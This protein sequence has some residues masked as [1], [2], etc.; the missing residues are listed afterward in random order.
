MSPEQSL[1]NAAVL[2]R[3]LAEDEAL[4]VFATLSPALADRLKGAMATN[5]AQAPKKQEEIPVKYT[6]LVAAHSQLVSDAGRYVRQ[7]L[8]QAFADELAPPAP[9]PAQDAPLSGLERLGRLDPATIAQVCGAE[10]PQVIAAILVRLERG[11][12]TAALNHLPQPTQADVLLRIARLQDIHPMALQDLDEVLSAT[13]DRLALAK[14]GA[15]GGLQTAIEL[16]SRSAV[17]V[18]SS[19]LE[20]IL[21]RDP[22]LAQKLTRNL[23]PSGARP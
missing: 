7:I 8:G 20:L 1:H 11:L 5:E 13:L 4:A 23:N 18:K 14:T 16:I 6:P 15:T 3:H 2:M 10:H 21:Q 22:V 9:A 17:T 19:L 12:A